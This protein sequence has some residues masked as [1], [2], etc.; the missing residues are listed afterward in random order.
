MHDERILKDILNFLVNFILIILIK[1]ILLKKR[2]PE[3]RMNILPYMALVY[4]YMER[5]R[6]NTV[7]FFCAVYKEQQESEKVRNVCSVYSAIVLN[8]MITQERER[9]LYLHPRNPLMHLF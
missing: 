2:V 3:K 7:N 4:L 1:C 8:I 5:I 9:T 6:P